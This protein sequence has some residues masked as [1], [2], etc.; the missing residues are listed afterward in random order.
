MTSPAITIQSDASLA[1]AAALMLS[2]RIGCLPVLDGSG[3]GKGRLI[4][5]ITDDSFFPREKQ[6]PYTHERLGWLFGEWLGDIDQLD[7]TLRSLRERPVTDGLI[8]RRPVAI[9]TPLPE[10]ARRLL[11]EHLHHV[12]VVR[13]D[14]VVGVI[15][16]HDMAKLVLMD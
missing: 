5:L 1:D 2:R 15:S 10:I 13:D 9:D 14:E 8:A 12:A 7:E 3:D 16:R 11:G 4:G 6:V